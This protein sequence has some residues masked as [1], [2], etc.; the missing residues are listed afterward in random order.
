MKTLSKTAMILAFFVVATMA[1]ADDATIK[2][3]ILGDWSTGRHT[4]TFKSD[5]I[6]YMMG[7]S[8]NLRWDVRNGMYYEAGGEGSIDF[9]QKGYKI[10][11]L[12][13]TRFVT[14]RG[15]NGIY[16]WKREPVK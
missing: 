15:E 1:H 11:S 8:S 5:G 2:K 16:T 4:F 14:D 3:K 7:G 13:S 10:L 9:A 12:T 6:A